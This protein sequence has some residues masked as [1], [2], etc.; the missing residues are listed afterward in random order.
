MWEIEFID[1]IYNLYIRIHQ[2]FISSKDGKPSSSAFKN[3][4]K[5]G[6]NLSSDWSKYCTPKTSRELIGLQKKRDGTLK[7]P[8]L[9]YIWEM[10]VGEIR[11][12][13][14]PTQS[15]NHAPIYNSPTIDGLPNNRAHSIIIGEKPTNNAEFRVG[16]YKIGNWAIA[17]KE[18]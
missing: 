15:V 9:F 13:I 6:D 1:N 14:N 7:N 16:L 12:D 3:T 10:N 5:D 11:K 2:T 8:S 17:P 4:P 18:D